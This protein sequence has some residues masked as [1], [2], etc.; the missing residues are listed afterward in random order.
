MAVM[1]QRPGHSVP[2]SPHPPQLPV[3]HREGQKAACFRSGGR[4]AA[5]PWAV[6][7]PTDWARSP[8]VSNTLHPEGRTKGPFML[9]FFF[10]YKE[11]HPLLPLSNLSF[12]FLG[13]RRHVGIHHLRGLIWH[14]LPTCH[15]SSQ[16][17]MELLMKS[18]RNRRLK[19]DSKCPKARPSDHLE[20]SLAHRK[21][22]AKTSLS[23]ILGKRNGWTDNTII[24]NYNRHMIRYV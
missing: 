4:N 5:R 14:T 13:L 24:I 18:Q 2:D 3:L 1:R 8:H 21:H 12:P 11:G 20:A 16:V 15:T 9:L 17:Y 10:F 6:A 7:S 22:S 19:E 23:N